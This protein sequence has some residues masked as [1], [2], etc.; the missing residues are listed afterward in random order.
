MAALGEPVNRQPSCSSHFAV[1][2]H[3]LPYTRSSTGQEVLQAAW[4]T[5]LAH[6]FQVHVTANRH[7]SDLNIHATVLNPLR[8]WIP[9]RYYADLGSEQV[10]LGL[11]GQETPGSWV[12]RVQCRREGTKTID[13]NNPWPCGLL[14]PWGRLY[15]MVSEQGHLKPGFKAGTSCAS[16]KDDAKISIYLGPPQDL[17][18]LC[19]QTQTP[20]FLI[21]S[22]Q[23]NECPWL[24]GFSFL[25]CRKYK[26]NF[27]TGRTCPSVLVIFL[28]SL[29]RKM[30]ARSALQSDASSAGQFTMSTFPDASSL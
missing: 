16:S 30:C 9:G 8:E 29:G 19:S 26:T 23:K 15:L 3:R 12:P 20:S 17:K 10:S 7:H 2:V 6:T 11:S 18:K 22:C 24:R 14:T 21:T 13:G 1:I 25:T 4:D 27:A 28:T 5:Q